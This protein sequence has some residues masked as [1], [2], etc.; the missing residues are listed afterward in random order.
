VEGVAESIDEMGA[1]LVRLSDGNVT[2]LY[3]A[4]I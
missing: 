1:L 2:K 4:E 3:S